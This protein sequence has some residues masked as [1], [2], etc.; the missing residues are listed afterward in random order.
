M[1]HP[2]T[3]AREV[4]PGA[5][6]VRFRT[7]SPSL[8]Y[9]VATY[10][11]VLGFFASVAPS[12]L[13]QT[14]A[15]LWHFS[16]LTLTLVYATYA[17]GVLATLLLTGSVSDN[18][19]RRPVLLAA[20]AVLVLSTLV[21][22]FASSV[23]WLVV[24]RALGG[25][26]TGAAISTASA[27]LLDLQPRR[28]TRVVAVTNG[29][30]SNGGLALAILAVSALVRVGWQPLVVP[31]LVQLG[32]LLVALL[33]VW[34][35]PEP[36]TE[37]TPLRLRVERPHVPQ[38]ARRPFLLAALGVLSSW[39]IAG[40]LFSLGPQLGAAVLDSTDAVVSG[41]G[42]VALLATAAVTQMALGRMVPWL[43]A[44]LGSVALAVG[45]LLTA[46]ATATG[47]G[48]LYLVGSVVNGFGFGLSFLGGLRG[49][50][51]AIPAEH[52]AAVMSAFYLVAYMSLSVPAILAGLLV[53]KL[54]LGTTFELFSAGAA[55]IALV[56]A[57]W[58]WR[59]R[60]QAHGARK[61]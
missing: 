44:S 40:L 49:L 11:I 20:L 23:A 36:I 57:V 39:S 7:L 58:A 3:K 38:V 52:R 8:G 59:M 45:I 16:P 46:V 6:L 35:M 51:G 30:A 2:T 14:Y 33:G 24:A 22:V 53:D 17:F 34:L 19:G 5:R 42:I 47:S 15:R 4:G 55:L 48:A 21:F 9:A 37:R 27:T 54:G 43:G 1:T 25:L 13:Y 12:P 18:L 50:V 26:A 28:D 31:Y 60:P 56:A 41:I 29:V 32:L 61:R 10:V